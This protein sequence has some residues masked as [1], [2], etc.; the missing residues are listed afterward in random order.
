[1]KNNKEREERLPSYWC[2]YKQEN[3]GEATE[4]ELFDIYFNSLS[5][6]DV[7]E[8]I[9]SI[10]TMAHNKNCSLSELKELMISV[11]KISELHGLLGQLSYYDKKSDLEAKEL[12]ISKENTFHSL[13][14]P[15][16]LEAMKRIEDSRT[17]D[18]PLTDEAPDSLLLKFT[19]ESEDEF[20]ILEKLHIYH[21]KFPR[22]AIYSTFLWDIEKKLD[23]VISNG[24]KPII[25][26][27]ELKKNPIEYNLAIDTCLTAIEDRI[28]SIKN[29]PEAIESCN[30]YYISFYVELDL[31][32]KRAAKRFRI[33][34]L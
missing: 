12:G 21:K 28:K 2:M 31:A 15:M 22:P 20:L 6:N 27:S 13:Y 23:Q 5:D 17:W 30:K 1:M 26:N 34:S 25:E 19:L 14:I 10:K 16:I 3:P 32:I 7:K 29:L 33:V 11:I 4:L 18:E 8:K 24:I 9:L